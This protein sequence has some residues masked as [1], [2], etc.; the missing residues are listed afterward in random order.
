MKRLALVAAL[1]ACTAH[2]AT[3]TTP[4][5]PAPPPVSAEPSF[6]A[7]AKQTRAGRFELDLVTRPARDITAADHL[8]FVLRTEGVEYGRYPIAAARGSKVAQ[9]VALPPGNYELVLEYFGHHTGGMM[10]KI[11]DVPYWGG[12]HKLYA[13]MH[14]GTRLLDDAKGGLQ[15]SIA[16]WW[17]DDTPTLPWIVEWRREGRP[18]IITSGRT[19]ETRQFGET[20]I[21]TKADEAYAR[22]GFAE[23][24]WHFSEIHPVPP[25][26]TSQPGKWEAWAVRAGARP[27]AI[28]FTL[29]PGGKIAKPSEVKY[30][31]D[32]PES[33]ELTVRDLPDT[34]AT[35]LVMQLPKIVGTSGFA[36]AKQNAGELA[37]EVALSPGAVRAMF[38]SKELAHEWR[39]YVEANHRVARVSSR[40]ETAKRAGPAEDTGKLAAQRAKIGKLIAANNAPWQ[41]NEQPD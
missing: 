36:P 25:Q 33:D 17:A 12:Q 2:P 3:S 39:A 40:E 29:L 20:A 1:A 30:R 38:R 16:R 13:S 26:V 18:V 22:P 11:S 41:P 15:L 6:E 5:N 27:L 37:E 14:R 23:T 21:V 8:A 9:H 32:E 34:D 31:F 10:V 19:E 24:P 28:A 35:H 4:A 7:S